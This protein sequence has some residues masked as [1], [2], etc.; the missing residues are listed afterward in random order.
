MDSVTSGHRY[1]DRSVVSRHRSNV[2]YDYCRDVFTSMR[3]IRDTVTVADGR[4]L[5][6]L[7]HGTIRIRF[8]GEWV[9]LHQVLYVPGLQGNLLSVGLLAE[10]GVMCLFSSQGAYLHQGGEMLAHARR[11][12]RNY[13][14]YPQDAHGA[15][16][17]AGQ[18]DGHD[19]GKSRG[20]DAGQNDTSQGKE[21][22]AYR[23][24]YRRLG[25]AGEE[26]IKFFQTA[27]EGIPGLVP[28]QR[29]TCKTC[30]LTKSAKTINRD[31]LQRTK[32]PL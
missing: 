26:K 7:G 16:M 23:L 18:D 1:T 22:D 32:K 4:Q 21:L 3:Q 5:A 31:A 11:V 2:T 29:Q 8:G 15:L 28:G 20:R 10:K 24:W 25:H 14:L 13:A 9:Q 12:G 19:T 27:V 6:S 17:T 30:A